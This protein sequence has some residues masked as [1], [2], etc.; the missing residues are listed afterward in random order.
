MHDTRT[1][2]VTGIAGFIGYH[3]AKRLVEDGWNVIGIDNCNDYYDPSLKH[4]R[5]AQLGNSVTFYLGDIEDKGLIESIFETHKPELVCHLAAQAGVRYSIENPDAYISSNIVGFLNILEACRRHKPR[6]LFYASSSSVYGANTDVPFRITD[7]VDQPVSLYA[8]TKRS[9]ELMAYCYNHL[10]QIPCTG[11]RFF[12][13]YGPW[14]RPDMAYFKFA[15]SILAG[16]PIDIYNHGNLSRDF[17]YIDDI[18]EGIIRLLGAADTNDDQVRASRWLAREGAHDAD[19]RAHADD[20]IRAHD[21]DAI[22]AHDDDAMRAHDDDA[23]WAHADDAIRASH[24]L[25]PTYNIGNGA[26]VS[27]LEFVQ[28][29]EQELGM[30]AIK[31]YVDMQPGDVAT[32]WADCEELFERTKF[33]PQTDLRTGLQRFV[34]WYK[35]YYRGGTL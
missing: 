2:L 34:A 19:A 13:V 11:L 9:N 21:D 35:E 25:A 6:H 23:S 10:Y 17:T 7:R 20:A 29:L 8:V 1:I 18:V 5:L 24:R 16:N 12:T 33:R 26:P 15:E 27:L 32:T 22:R 30:P 28:T 4:A 3:V 31:E 14:G